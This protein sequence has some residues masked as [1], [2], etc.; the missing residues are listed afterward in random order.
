MNFYFQKRDPKIY[1]GGFIFQCA[2]CNDSFGSE[3]QLVR[4][5]T[6]KHEPNQCSKCS[7]VFQDVEELRRHWGVQH[8]KSFVCVK[9]GKIYKIQSCLW[10]HFKNCHTLP[11]EVDHSYAK[12][13][14]DI[15]FEIPSENMLQ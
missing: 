10:K 4:H 1:A 6:V 3:A 8:N 5:F 12:F 13:P 7:D 11:C 14:F 9:C 2:F 15:M